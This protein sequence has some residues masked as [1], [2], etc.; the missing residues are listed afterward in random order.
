MS[1]QPDDLTPFTRA[2]AAVPPHPGQLDRDA[3]L[4]AAG[5]AAG[6]RG[7]FWPALSAGLACLSAALALVL[8][9]RPPVVVQVEHIVHIPTPAPA[10]T[11]PP[12]QDDGP[13]PAQPSP[14]VAEGMRLRKGIL[15][16]GADT[17]PQTPWA[18]SSHDD[19]PTLTSLR[20]NATHA[21]G[22]PL[23]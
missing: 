13:T 15:Q 10:D 20:L 7:R 21:D 2:L 11:T 22:G 14:T 8:L 6:R 3:L 9:L 23:R 19:V 12:E 16:D 1:A 17:Q 5:R 4:F 18:A